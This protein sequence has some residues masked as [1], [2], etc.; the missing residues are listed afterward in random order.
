ME[1]YRSMKKY[2][3]MKQCMA[4]CLILGLLLS[5]AP[6]P[7]R[8]AEI[9][10][11]VQGKVMS[12]TTPELLYLSTREGTMQIKLDS[13][14][15]TSGCKILL[16]DKTVSVAVSHG[17]D[18]Y[19]H[20]V[21]ITNNEASVNV[22]VDT[23]AT[24]TVTGTISEKSTGD[25]LR[26]NTP[27]GEMQIKLDASTTI[28]CSVLV[29]GRNYR[30]TCA[31]GSDAFMHAVSISD[32]GGST[33]PI[34]TGS[35]LTPAP[36][37]PITDATVTVTGRVADK[38]KVG[39][40]YLATDGGEMQIVIDS[41]TDTRN[42]LVLVPGTRLTVSVYRGSDAFMHA[43][44]VTSTKSAAT[45]AAI[46]T[47]STAT[48]SGIVGSKSTEDLL[49]LYTPQGEMQLKLDGVRSVT[50]CKAFFRGQRLN[51]VCGY[52]SDAFMHALDITGA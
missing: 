31:R 37:G 45:S 51:V 43:A 50:N 17:N 20:A 41:Y 24:A 44:T 19:L 47:S 42:A 3:R 2:R 25:L 16:P 12:Q 10:A 8:A 15:D 5:V 28:N 49:Y 35:S 46:N 13:N 6:L 27:Q 36:A 32:D 1:R 9:L 29:A 34:L 33:A 30:I 40:L 18:G 48:V 7:L 22:T 52:G 14:T 23:S 26:F 38:T 21:K 11:T 39:L 4:V